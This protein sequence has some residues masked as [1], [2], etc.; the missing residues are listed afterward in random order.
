MNQCTESVRTVP[1]AA[2]LVLLSL[3]GM[4]IVLFIY[5]LGAWGKF[6]SPCLLCKMGMISV[7][8]SRRFRESVWE[9]S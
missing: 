2:Q 3:I 1:A 6:D 9:D 4:A 8:L 7:R 5:S